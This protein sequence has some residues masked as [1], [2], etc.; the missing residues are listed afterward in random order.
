M[1]N[2]LSKKSTQMDTSHAAIDSLTK[3]FLYQI[4]SGILKNT[5]KHVNRRLSKIMVLFHL[6]SSS[7]IFWLWTA[8]ALVCYIVYAG[9][10]AIPVE[11]IDAII[12]VTAPVLLNNHYF[13]GRM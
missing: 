11:Q 6:A 7:G 8:I 13:C 1:W 9:L 5:A 12:K 2:T 10:S 4:A 3:S